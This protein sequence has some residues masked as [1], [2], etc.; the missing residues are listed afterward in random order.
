MEGVGGGLA[1]DLLALCWEQLWMERP[2]RGAG[3]VGVNLTSIVLDKGNRNVC[4]A[5]AFDEALQSLEDLRPVVH[6]H[7]RLELVHL[8]I[9]NQEHPRIMEH[10]VPMSYHALMMKLQTVTILLAVGWTIG[11]LV[12][13]AL[14]LASGYADIFP[15]QM[16]LGIALCFGAGL[17]DRLNVQAG[18]WRRGARAGATM[19]LLLIGPY[20]ILTAIILKPSPDAGGET[21]L[22]LLLEAPLWLGLTFGSG[23][24]FGALGWRVGA[25]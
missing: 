7:R 2:A 14:G 17:R 12:Q 1:V 3:K 5:S 8:R 20:L 25:R 9:D 10:A 6:R 22:T 23:A 16:L 18:S 11:F 15:P 4:R 19:M 21:W 13:L 24:L